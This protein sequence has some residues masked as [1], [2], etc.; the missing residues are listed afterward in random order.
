MCASVQKIFFFLA[1]TTLKM[2]GLMYDDKCVKLKIFHTSGRSWL[3]L[4][5]HHNCAFPCGSS[6]TTLSCCV[7]K[8]N[9]A[10]ASSQLCVCLRLQLHYIAL[11]CKKYHSSRTLIY[12]AAV[13]RGNTEGFFWGGGDGVRTGWTPY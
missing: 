9:T 12:F 4:R 5:L 1:F 10:P 3:R 11:L 7:K 2:A 8:N 6:S 13:L